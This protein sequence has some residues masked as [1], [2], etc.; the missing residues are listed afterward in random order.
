VVGPDG[1]D[2][3]LGLGEGV[4]HGGPATDLGVAVVVDKDVKEVV[5]ELGGDLVGVGETLPGG[6]G[7]VDA[8]A[9]LDE[10]LLDGGLGE[11]SD[12]AV[13][14][15]LVWPLFTSSCLIGVKKRGR[16][17]YVKGAEVST[18]LPSP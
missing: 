2:E 17:T 13:I 8:G 9:V 11:L 1:E 14:G 12:D 18:C 10:E 15:M 16:V 4:D 7:N 3:D 5:A 6:G